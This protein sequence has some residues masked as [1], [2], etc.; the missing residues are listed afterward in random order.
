MR[1]LAFGDVHY[2]WDKVFSSRGRL[3]KQPI[4]DIRAFRVML[5]FAKEY[6]PDIIVMAG[7]IADMSP[8]CHHEFDRPKNLEAQRL[9][10]VYEKLD[11]DII[12][13][14]EALGA[15]TVYWIDGSHEAW[16][17]KLASRIPGIDGLIDPFHYLRLAECGFLYQPVGS[18]V[19]L[20]KLAFA[21]GDTI[22]TSR[23]NAAKRAVERFGSSI[24]IWHHHTYQVFTKE[25]L[26]NLAYQTGVAVP[27]LCSRGPRYQQTHLNSW[28]KGFLYGVIERN[29]FHDYVAVIWKNRLQTGDGHV[30]KA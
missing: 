10:E 19:T 16:A 23:L 24:R 25:T 29:G 9:Q 1:F 7:D 8:I 12:Q 21:H 17:A 11:E 2:G 6:R 28:V 20:G 18:I 3:R 26:K 15:S 13:P 5:K 30:Y 4:H 22:T 14:V 27:C